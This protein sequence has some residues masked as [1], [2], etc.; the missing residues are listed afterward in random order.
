MA[1][2]ASQLGIATALR[3]EFIRA[4]IAEAFGATKEVVNI[5]QQALDLVDRHVAAFGSTE[6]AVATRSLGSRL[7]GIGVRA[8]LNQQDIDALFVLIDRVRTLESRRRSQES[9]QVRDLLLQ[10]RR[11]RRAGF[12][13]RIHGVVDDTSGRDAA[14]LERRIRELAHTRVGTSSSRSSSSIED[15][16]RLLDDSEMLVFFDVDDRLLCLQLSTDSADILEIGAAKA[17]YN[18]I[19][20]IRMRLSLALAAANPNSDVVSRLQSSIERL[21]QTV[22]PTPRASGPMIL[23]PPETTYGFPWGLAPALESRPIH[24]NPSPSA[25]VRARAERPNG[26]RTTAFVAGPSPAGA[27]REV[28]DLAEATHGSVG[29]AGPNATAEAVLET[30]GNCS[31]IHFATH[32]TVRADNPLF[33]SLELHDGPITLYELQ[34]EPCPAEVILSSCSVGRARSYPGGLAIGMPAVLL[35]GGAKTVVASEVDVPNEPTRAVMQALY[36]S[37][38]TG[39][40]PARALSVATAS[41]KPGS[42]EHLTAAAFNAYGA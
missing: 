17:I 31:R 25:W 27:E 15:V 23:I 32:G 26:E 14:S 36:E 35:A 40:D 5:P 10:Y 22:L 29:L 4:R 28:A 30:I 34:D 39:L 6:L 18:D 1:D 13:G 41:F 38:D 19:A 16:Q 21:S 8:A 33:S 3:F 9:P 2:E 20:K 12:E 11:A 42:T 24:V 37:L 7:A